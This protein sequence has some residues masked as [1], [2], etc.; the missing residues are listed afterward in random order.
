MLSGQSK[1]VART[2]SYSFYGCSSRGADLLPGALI[3]HLARVDVDLRDRC[4]LALVVLHFSMDSSPTD[5][6]RRYQMR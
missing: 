5:M 4:E 2:L 3:E 1:N 6:C